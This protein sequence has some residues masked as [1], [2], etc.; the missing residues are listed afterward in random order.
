MVTMTE[1]G[2]TFDLCIVLRKAISNKSWMQILSIDNRIGSL[3]VLILEIR[4][5]LVLSPH[6]GVVSALLF[7]EI[8]WLSHIGV[9]W[10]PVRGAPFLCLFTHGGYRCSRYILTYYSVCPEQ[11]GNVTSCAS[12]CFSLEILPDTGWMNWLLVESLICSINQ[13][14]FYQ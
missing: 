2:Q 1:S 8:T 6:H 12:E 5:F 13:C 7:P 9:V 3:K 10:V 4:L 14:M 11:T